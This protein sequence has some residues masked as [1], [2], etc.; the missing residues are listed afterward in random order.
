VPE[1]TPV[2]SFYITTK[3]FVDPTV[4][5]N[6]W[7]LTFKGMVDNPYSLDLKQLKALPT[8][9]RAQTLA[10]ISNSVG[11]PLIGNANWKGVSFLSL[12]Q[13]AKP[14]AGVVDVV[15]RAADGYADSFPLDVALKND[16]AL[17]YEMEGKPLTQKHGYPARLLVPN[18]YGMK[19]CKWITEVE[20]VNSDFKGYWEEQ[21]WDDVAHYQTMS[22]I[23]YPNSN[24]IPAKPIYVGGVAFA[25]NRGIKKVEVSTDGGK[26][27]NEASLRPPTGKY[28]WV[29]W[30]YPWKPASGSYTLAVRATDGTGA[31]QTSNVQDTY[32]NGA[33]GYHTIQVR[34]A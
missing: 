9:E 34:V 5:G 21:G 24:N 28:T 2:S 15:V 4:D 33:T 26:T 23:D 18:I 30:T 22:R 27:W 12:L 25:G 8:L 16:C 31:L 19:N 6:S 3:N 13:R 32:P 29:Q 11:G 14:Q 20:L 17:V 1:F 10:C 7:K